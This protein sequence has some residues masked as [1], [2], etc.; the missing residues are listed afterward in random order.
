MKM[1]PEHS[2]SRL[3]S[4]RFAIFEGGFVRFKG[5]SLGVGIQRKVQVNRPL[6]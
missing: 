6:N 2:T 4:K 5:D 3:S 1:T